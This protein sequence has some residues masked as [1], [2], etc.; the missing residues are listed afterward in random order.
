MGTLLHTDFAPAERSAL[1]VV[2]NQFNAFST[3]PLLLEF[4]N[5]LPTIFLILNQQRQVVYANHRLLDLLDVPDTDTVLGKRPGE[6]LDCV[7]ASENDCGCGT[8]IFCRTCGAVRAIL[9]SLDGHKAL[10]ECRI[11]QRSGKSLD[12]RIS[13]TPLALDGEN[14][15]MFVVEDI[16]D[17]KRRQVLE[18]LFY[19]DILNLAGIIAGYAGSLEQTFDVDHAD[20]IKDILSRASFRLADVVKSQREITEAESG[21]LVVHPQDIHSLELLQSVKQFYE[22]HSITQDRTILIAPDAQDVVFLSDPVLLERVI[23]NLVKN[24]LEACQPGETAT[25]ICRQEEQR[26][27]FE[28]HNPA[29]MPVDVQLQLFQRSFSTKGAGR[30]LGTYSI[31]LFSEQYLKGTVNFTSSPEHGTT[32]C[33]CYPLGYESRRSI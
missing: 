31:K 27:V 15:S 33:V 5:A 17:E 20:R 12:L 4:L 18:R 16:S 13:A 7:H 8:T 14:Y 3:D 9:A 28:V 19:H 11:T 30:G 6:L 25:L 24:A 22:G 1:D 29:W 10:E 21:E 32:F 2:Q 26:V 23:G